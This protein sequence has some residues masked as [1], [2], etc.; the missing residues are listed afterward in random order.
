MRWGGDVR[1]GVWLELGHIEDRVDARHPRRETIQ[2]ICIGA[3]ASTNTEETQP[4]GRKLA[5]AVQQ[6]GI[7]GVKH[8]LLANF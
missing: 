1:Q 2:Q 4:S 7:S 3:A 5:L 6:Q 8:D